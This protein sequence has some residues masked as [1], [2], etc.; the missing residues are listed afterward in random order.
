MMGWMRVPGVGGGACWR[1]SVRLPTGCVDDASRDAS[2][3]RGL[4]G[5]GG[6]AEGWLRGRGAA[7]AAVC[8]AMVRAVADPWAALSPD[9][10]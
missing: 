4:G 2:S 3:E 9:A 1:G 10:R 8:R 7:V 5:A 6:P